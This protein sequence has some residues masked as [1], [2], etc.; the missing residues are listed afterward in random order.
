MKELGPCHQSRIVLSSISSGGVN[1]IHHVPA[2]YGTFSVTTELRISIITTLVLESTTKG[3]VTKAIQWKL[4][5]PY[6][7][8]AQSPEFSHLFTSDQEVN[9]ASNQF[10][11]RKTTQGIEVFYNPR[12]HASGQHAD[13]YPSRNLTK[14]TQ[15]A[16]DTSS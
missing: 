14:P 11:L 1:K 13:I 8:A 10:I 2:E 16:V 15:C 7:T 5:P 9:I 12:G 4:T 3:Q 6:M